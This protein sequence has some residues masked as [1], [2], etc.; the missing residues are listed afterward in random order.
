MAQQITL[1]IEDSSVVASLRKVLSL[2]DGV[3][4]V[5]PSKS[6]DKKEQRKLTPY[7]QSREDVRC[8]RVTTYKSLED[9]YAKMGI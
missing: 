8:G 4:I 1:S 9:F 3:T 7:E 5:N 6:R 2:M